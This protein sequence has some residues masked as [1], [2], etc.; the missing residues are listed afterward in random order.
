[1]ATHHSCSSSSTTA[2]SDSSSQLS[3]RDNS[4]APTRPAIHCSGSLSIAD[5]L[6]DPK[7]PHEK[8]K[9][10]FSTLEAIFQ[11]AE[12]A[13][14]G[15]GVGELQAVFEHADESSRAGYRD[16][17]ALSNVRGILNQMWWSDSEFIASAA[18]VLADGSRDPEWR[19][20]F[21]EAG[22][23]DFFLGIVAMDGVEHKLMLHTL[24][25]IGNSCADEDSNRERVVGHNS[26]LPIVRLLRDTSLS[27]IAISVVYNICMDFEPA[28]KQAAEYGCFPV[29]I[30]VLSN[31]QYVGNPLLNYICR[32]LESTISLPPGLELSP[33]NAVEILLGTAS[34][35][36]TEL[37]D[38]VSLVNVAVAHLRE[39]RFQKL[40]VGR[41]AVEI[42]LALLVRSYSLQTS[43]ESPLAMSDPEISSHAPEEEQQL[44]AMRSHVVQA[45]SDISALPEFAAN[46]ALESPLIGSLR[47]WL[48]VSQPQLQVCAC[49]MLGNLARSDDVCRIM[50]HRF[51][52]H[53]PLITL[54]QE[55]DDT[56][57]LYSA[58]GFLKNLALPSDNKAAIGEAGLIKTL[59]RLW[60]MDTVPQVQYVSACLTRQIISNSYANIQTLLASLSPDL[61]SPAH[62]K[63][64]L[65]LLLSL[66][67]K[68]D[69]SPTKTE[70]ART[71]TA[72]CR[73]LN[74]PQP[75]ISSRS[76]EETT[77]RLYALHPDLGRPLAIMVSQSRWPVVR[78]EGWFAF[79]LMARSK[80]GS[81]AVSD[82]MQVVE[83]FRPLVETIT[84]KT[85]ARGREY[86]ALQDITNQGE[87]VDDVEDLEAREG[88]T[89][90][91]RQMRA[92]DRDN[93]LVL[94]S[95]LLRNR[96]EE[97]AIIRRGV[98][99]D[100]LQG[101]NL[102]LS[103][104]E[105]MNR[106][107]AFESENTGEIEGAYEAMGDQ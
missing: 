78:S 72:I 17:E 98:F 12:E 30:D 5:S 73:A 58:A 61:D 76:I 102:H 4:P 31:Q 94:V 20:P 18:E 1:M 28:Q 3:S 77:H 50:V 107:Q 91:E 16:V 99:E 6:K 38:C 103:Y 13:E 95:E 29:L 96:G 44:S 68:S 7:I 15:V 105:L 75:G 101:R 37:D 70:I 26:L 9:R 23:L 87:L 46:Y 43:P 81:A 52:I 63:T 55:S 35:T 84:G 14:G 34:E 56:Q 83:V 82:V 48:S 32:L 41:Q 57:A 42:P 100:L 60:T 93:T 74:S 24:R 106:A 67:E 89:E 19:I 8:Q 92:R 85:I 90:Q 45:L 51:Q 64:Y 49:I 65:S 104:R 40:L 88:E 47:M 79:A 11:R 53:E 66:D 86:G 27:S 54:L 62:E 21:G 36:A 2:S 71:I 97:M 69:D 33:E 59:P 80:E 22:V 39:E 10:M 25:L